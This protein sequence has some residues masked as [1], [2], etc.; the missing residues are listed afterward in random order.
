MYIK[1]TWICPAYN[2]E[3]NSNSEK[4][5]I[6]LMVPNKEKEGLNYLALRKTTG[7]IKRTAII[8]RN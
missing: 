4:L 2:S 5:I 7:I 3:L 1:E 8:K 6:L